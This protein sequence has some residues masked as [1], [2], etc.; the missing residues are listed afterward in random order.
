MTAKT[1]EEER[2]NADGAVS[3]RSSTALSTYRS[4]VLPRSARKGAEG[5]GGGSIRRYEQKTVLGRG[6]SGEVTLEHDHDIDRPVAVKRV[7]T[8]AI[9]TELVARFAEEVRTVG[10]LEHPN[11]VPIHDVGID[12][13]QRHYF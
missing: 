5:T 2:A 7:R 13:R 1:A 9:E 11:I 6:A 4:T 12:E 3:V 8:N 10:G